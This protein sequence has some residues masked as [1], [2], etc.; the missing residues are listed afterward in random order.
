MNPRQFEQQQQHQGP[1]CSRSDILPYD[2]IKIDN[3]LYQVAQFYKGRALVKLS[4]LTAA[5]ICFDQVKKSHNFYGPAQFCKAQCLYN[6]DQFHDAI[7]VLSNISKYE[8]FFPKVLALINKCEHHIQSLELPHQFECNINM[9][10]AQSD[11]EVPFL[12]SD[13]SLER[14][15][16]SFTEYH[17]IV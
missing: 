15:G 14:L 3:P 13:T 9:Q 17:D 7:V 1:W 5:I 10:K 4:L 16:K 6:Q 2:S 12:G 8:V 11:N